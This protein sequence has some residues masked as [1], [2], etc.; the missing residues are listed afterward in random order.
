M[1]TIHTPLNSHNMPPPRLNSYPIRAAAIHDPCPSTAP[2][3]RLRA[4]IPRTRPGRA[5]TQGRPRRPQASAGDA[6]LAELHDEL[7]AYPG[8]EAKRPEPTDVIVPLRYRTDQGEL[9]FLSITAVIGTPL[10]ITVE[11]LAIESFYPADQAT[12]EAATARFHRGP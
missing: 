9:S 12:A 8:G 2:P 10:D 11:E 3:R 6:R 1:G 4:E 5:G 7:A